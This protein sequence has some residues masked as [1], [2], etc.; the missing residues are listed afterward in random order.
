[1][2]NSWEEIK[3]A[4]ERIENE[5]LIEELSL[6]EH[7]EKFIEE[8]PLRNER[9]KS[10]L[11]FLGELTVGVTVGVFIVIFNFLLFNRILHIEF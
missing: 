7:E 6:V 9:A 8:K 3:E 5:K 10:Y 4:V 1:M 2:P 11:D